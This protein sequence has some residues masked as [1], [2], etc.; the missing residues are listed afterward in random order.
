MRLVQIGSDT[1]PAIGQGTWQMGVDPSQRSREIDALRYGVEQGLALIDTAEMYAQGGCER[2][3]GDAVRDIRDR[4]FI[5]TKA[6]PNHHGASDLPAAL[7]GSLDRLGVDR[8]DLYLLHWPSRDTALAETV[9]ALAK[10][11][12]DGL[13]RFIGV[14][15]FP[16]PH[17]QQAEALLPAG[18]LIAAD[19]VEY[20]LLNRRAETALIPYAAEKTGLAVMAY[21]PLKD[22]FAAPH[23]HSGMAVLR[24][25][26]QAHQIFPQTAALAYLIGSGPVAAIPKAVQR[27]HIDANRAALDVELTRDE[28]SRI[29]RAFHSPPQELP[30]EAL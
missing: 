21:S 5:V 11:L 10:L 13:T 3:V 6:W 30:Y 24:D 9:P 2:V 27:T 16:T 29:Q 26:A 17:L 7:Q 8:V 28:R 1:V 18:A 12:R 22:V 19:Q 15:N 23:R 14:S 25:I 4:V 20:H